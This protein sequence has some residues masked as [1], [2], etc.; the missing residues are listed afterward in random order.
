MNISKELERKSN[1]PPRL[2]N[3]TPP[4]KTNIQWLTPH[5]N[6]VDQIDSIP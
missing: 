2:M 3:S 5:I 6:I 1:I 4:T